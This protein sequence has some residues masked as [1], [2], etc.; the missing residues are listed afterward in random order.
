MTLSKLTDHRSKA[1]TQSRMNEC[2]ERQR[3]VFFLNAFFCLS[4]LKKKGEVTLSSA[5]RIC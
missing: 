3:N 2:T 1:C 5:A 4:I